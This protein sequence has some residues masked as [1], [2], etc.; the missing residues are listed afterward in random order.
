M[1]DT[2]YR[3][4]LEAHHRE[5]Y[6]WA[7]A[8]CSRHPDDAET[9]LQAAYLK[10]LEGRARFAGASSFRTWLFAVVRNTAKDFRRR[11]WLGRLRL[12]KHAERGR[13]EGS[14]SFEEDVY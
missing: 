1:D 7:L 4:E 5:A 10:I 9:V 2:D 12:A 11:E 8:C 14:R 6:G 13:S 3:N